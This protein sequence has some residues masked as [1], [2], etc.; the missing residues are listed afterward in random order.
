MSALPCPFCGRAPHIGPAR[1]D[2][3]GN[4][5]AE[6]VCLNRRCVTYDERFRRGVT[7]RDGALSCD[8]RGSAA[9]KRAA[10]RRWNRRASAASP[11]LGVSQE[12][13]DPLS[14][15]ERKAP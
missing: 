9:Y 15:P 14:T 5:W 1:P 12:E 6:V 8:E 3:D 10:I 2:L 13:P 7:V 4:A 11:R